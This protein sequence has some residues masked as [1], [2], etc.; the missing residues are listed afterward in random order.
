[1]A[2]SDTGIGIPANRLNQLFSAFVQA[3]A[4]TSRKFGGTGLGLVISRRMAEMMNG[5]LDVT[6][7]E[8][9]GSTFIARLPLPLDPNLP[10][11]TAPI[12][13]LNGERILVVDDNEMNGRIVC[14]Q[15]T[16][17]GAQA[18]AMT[19]P[20][21]ALMSIY[22]Q[23]ST[24]TPFSVV[25]IDQQMPV[26]NGE[27]LAA[28][29]KGE[30][31]NKG[32]SLILMVASGQQGDPQWLADKGFAGYLP[33]PTRQEVLA[34]VI[35]NAI[36]RRQQGLVELVT[37]YSLSSTAQNKINPSQPVPV[38]VS[39]GQSKRVLLAE[40]NPINQMIARTMLQKLGM[41]VTVVNNGQ[42]AFDKVK[43]EHF[44]LIYMD[45]QMPV[46]D[47]YE[48]TVAI[49]SREATMGLPRMPIV[50]MT[51]NAMAQDREL[52]LAAGMD[53]HFPKPFKEKQLAESVKRWLTAK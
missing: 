48:A 19:N 36:K 5:T 32:L 44:D 31:I 43:Q 17:L 42:D 27:N 51:A 24:A 53:D 29:I 16:T 46:M 2:V 22:A 7:I 23:A 6:S 25:L 49:R 21:V 50:A 1:M 38:V 3:D 11:N 20:A 14:E 41:E 8:G 9:K 13:V 4:S 12:T 10:T 52:C 26:M 39:A 37:P 35:S 34:G 28:A 33:K 15:L 40:D 45:C 18:E 47:G 30:A